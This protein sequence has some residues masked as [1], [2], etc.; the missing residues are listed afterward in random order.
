MATNPDDIRLSEEQK[1]LIAERAD[2]SGQPW[3][4]ILQE[5]LA[6]E[7]AKDDEGL[8]TEFM[9]WCAE[10]VG[11]KDVISLEEARRILAKCSGSFAQDI[12]ADREDRL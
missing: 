9:D 1:R 4:A 3:Q 11:G 7:S 6:S 8:D 2:R 5:A 12:I 10:Q